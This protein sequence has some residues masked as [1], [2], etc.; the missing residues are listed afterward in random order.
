MLDS[1]DT[2]ENIMLSN[3]F[4]ESFVVSR[5][6]FF[7]VT[8]DLISADIGSTIGVYFGKD[9]NWSLRK[10]IEVLEPSYL[11]ISTNLKPPY[12]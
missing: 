9:K 11:E 4:L 8:L 2:S 1:E 10:L 7:E 3:S 5:A 12:L 6:L